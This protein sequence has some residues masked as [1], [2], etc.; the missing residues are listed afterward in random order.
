[1]KN[2]IIK[3]IIC[4]LLLV[5]STS[6]STTFDRYMPPKAAE[7]PYSKN[8]NFEFS[9][10]TFSFEIPICQTI[11]SF[12]LQEDNDEDENEVNISASV[13]T[14]SCIHIV[15]CKMSEE[16]SSDINELFNDELFELF[17]VRLLDRTQYN[18]GDL[19][20]YDSKYLLMGINQLLHQRKIVGTDSY[21][22][23]TFVLDVSTLIDADSNGKEHEQFVESFDFD[24]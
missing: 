20:I 22:G 18:E 10:V 6:Y 2:K 23:R 19:T 7:C 17:G 12:D 11:N 24:I 8:F 21:T 13:E 16:T 14:S 4:M 5:A 9:D 3:S 1:M 15:D